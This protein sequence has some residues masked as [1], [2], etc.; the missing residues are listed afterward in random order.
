MRYL[1]AGLAFV[2]C[3]CHLPLFLALFGGTAL[4]AG[5]RDHIVVALVALTGLFALSVWAA[6]RMF[7][8]S[9][10]EGAESRGRR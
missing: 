10:S 4:G 5:V 7:T 6:M 1:V 9:S 3:P 2:T 8:A